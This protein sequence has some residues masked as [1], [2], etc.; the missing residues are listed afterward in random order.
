[1]VKEHLSFCVID[2]NSR[3]REELVSYLQTR[4]TDFSVFPFENDHIDIIQ[5]IQDNMISFVCIAFSQENDTCLQLIKKIHSDFPQIVIISCIPANDREALLQC[6]HCGAHFSMNLPYTDDEIQCILTRAIEYQSLLQV[7]QVQHHHLRTSDGFC[8]IVGHS[9][10]IVEVFSTIEKVSKHDQATVL[11]QGES[12][13]GKELVAKAI[14]KLSSRRNQNFV[15]INCAAIPED[16]L[17][18]ELFGYV[19]GAFTGA[20]QS[21]QGRLSYANGGTLFLDEIGD[22]KLSLQ[23]KL[24]R[25]LQEGEYEPI[26]SVTSQ[27][28]NVRV[29]AATNRDLQKAVQD[30]HFRED[31]FYR[32]HV[33]PLHVPPLRQRTEDIPLLVEKFVLLNKRSDNQGI[34][35]FSSNALAALKQYSWPGNVRELENLVQRLSILNPGETITTSKLPQ[36]FPRF[37]TCSGQEKEEDQCNIVIQD[38]GDFYSQ[39]SEFEDRLILQALVKANGN[40]Q[41]AAKILKMKRTTLMEKI[42]RKQLNKYYRQQSEIV[43][44]VK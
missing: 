24:L 3:Q 30:G 14:H 40:K 39:I 16:L 10:K 5:L 1:M 7:S 17:E 23:G 37:V 8:G 9:E 6:L 43:A 12:G 44:N 2:E 19:K 33:I 32:L 34:Q 29:I 22:M 21:K 26:G 20:N 18:S 28:I 42:K 41:L 11:V 25:V 36:N 35:G 27:S 38:E 15:P 31:L 13:T 4:F